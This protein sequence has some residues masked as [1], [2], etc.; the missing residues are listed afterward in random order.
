[1]KEWN[2]VSVD[3]AQAS[4][5]AGMGKSDPNVG[6]AATP[7]TGAHVAAPAHESIM[8]WLAAVPDW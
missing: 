3:A 2:E 6:S 8:E 1:M 4:A 7:T 5:A